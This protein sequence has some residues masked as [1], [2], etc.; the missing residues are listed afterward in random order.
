MG[1][2]KSSSSRLEAA[3]TFLYQTLCAMRNARQVFGESRFV[4]CAMLYT[5]GIHHPDT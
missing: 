2:A 4:P 5:P 3:P 1:L